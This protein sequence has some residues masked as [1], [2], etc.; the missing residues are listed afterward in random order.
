M[1]ILCKNIKQLIYKLKFYK[2]NIYRG[3]GSNFLGVRT[4]ATKLRGLDTN[5]SPD[6]LSLTPQA[7]TGYFVAPFC[8]IIFFLVKPYFH[9]LVNFKKVLWIDY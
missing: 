3:A 4:K 5:I 6:R 8:V 1:Y 9:F 2:G 7:F